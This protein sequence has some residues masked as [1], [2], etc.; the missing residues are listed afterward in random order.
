MMITS[1]RSG[2]CRSTRAKVSSHESQV[3][4]DFVAMGA[5]S[6]VLL[7]ACDPSPANAMIREAYQVA[8]GPSLEQSNVETVNR[9]FELFGAGKVTEI[10]TLFSEKATSVFPGTPRLPWA[11][12]WAGRDSFL[13]FLDAF[14]KFESVKILSD[15]Y[16]T[17]EKGDVA[18]FVEEEDANKQTGKTFN[19]TCALRFK[20]DDKGK[21]L[22]F[23]DICN[24]LLEYEAMSKENVNT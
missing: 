18:V 13:Q 14:D 8:E 2:P 4:K 7:A 24:T 23:E 15:T 22:Y 17:N 9:I 6:L 10:P 19:M 21:V 11:G 1:S 16:F 12:K 5:S 3:S 20:F